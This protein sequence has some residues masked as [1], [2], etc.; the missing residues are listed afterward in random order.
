MMEGGSVPVRR[1]LRKIEKDYTGGRNFWKS[2]V[3]PYLDCGDCFMGVYIPKAT[4]LYTSKNYGLLYDNY[5]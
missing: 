5:T 1:H 2:R 4:K 3:F